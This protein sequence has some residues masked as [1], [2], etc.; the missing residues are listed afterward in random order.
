MISIY[1]I[2]S[3]ILYPILIIVVL[4][5]KILKKEDKFRFKEKIFS[6]TFFRVFKNNKRIIWFHAASLGEVQSIIPIINEL[7]ST[8][9][10]NFLITTITTSS[11]SFI[12]EKFK[13]CDN[14]IHKYLPLDVNFLIK[15]FIIIWK[16]HAVFFVD[17]EI[18]PNLIYNLKY[19]NIPIAIINGRLTRKTYKRWKSISKTSFD[20]FN[21]FDLILSSSLESKSY[22][23][24]LGGKK[25][26][27]LGNIKFLNKI[28]LESIPKTN[29]SFLKNK[30][31]WCAVS[32]HNNEE[33]FCIETHIKLKDNIKDI[34]TI[35]IPRHINRSFKIKNLC[36]KYKLNTQILD[37]GEKISKNSEIVIINSFGGLSEYLVHAKS[38]LIGKSL[39]KK[40][41]NDGGQNPILAAQLG[42]KVYYGPY[43]KNFQD[44]YNFLDEKN[45]SKQISSTSELS[46]SL[47]NDL[48]NNAKD[49]EKSKKVIDSISNVIFEETKKKINKFV[50]YEN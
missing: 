24:E 14:I 49:L 46:I 30:V 2:L 9:Q 38:V 28:N 20:L 47:L 16:P 29:E 43:V 37:K 10:F 31:F 4:L 34:L 48:K 15:K 44:I 12:E 13:D 42:C 41:E 18:W 33:K 32:T 5:R 23:E 50:N 40:L 36:A 22:L 8:K 27:Y 7:N 17:S 26:F 6:S 1:R 45:I 35:I 19:N 21:K 25:V 39:L 11:A 3:T